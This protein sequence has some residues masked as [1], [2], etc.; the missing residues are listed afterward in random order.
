MNNRERAGQGE[1]AW[2]GSMAASP[3]AWDPYEVWLTRVK[4]P[5]ESS[6]REQT[7]ASVAITPGA[8]RSEDVRWS[9]WRRVTSPRS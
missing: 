3:A 1:S 4:Q 6:P 9:P 2:Q 5:R 7:P 8:D